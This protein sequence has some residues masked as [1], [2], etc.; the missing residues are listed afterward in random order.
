[1][2]PGHPLF[3]SL[4]HDQFQEKVA[5]IHVHVFVLVESG[6]KDQKDDGCPRSLL[7]CG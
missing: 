7:E 2:N 3:S 6:K 5:R 4:P 1:M